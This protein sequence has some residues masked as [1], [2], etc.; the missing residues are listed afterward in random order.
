MMGSLSP[1]L[2]G[3]RTWD[4]ENAGEGKPKPYSEEKGFGLF[5]LNLFCSVVKV[6]RQRSLIRFPV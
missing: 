3:N 6:S 5:C 2:K 1:S 4:P